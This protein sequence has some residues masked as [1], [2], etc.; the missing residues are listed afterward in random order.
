MPK[1]LTQDLVPGMITAEDIYTYT[2]QL[3]LPKDLVLTDKAI[4]KL[5]FYSVVSIRIKDETDEAEP[6]EELTYSEKIKSSPEFIKFAQD[7]EK[8]V[9]EV[10]SSLD[11]ILVQKNV[12][13]NVDKLLTEAQNL[14]K[15]SHNT[16][17]LFDMLHNMRYYDDP[18]YSHSLNV[19]VI[20]YAFGKW[21][22]FPDEDMN[23]LLLCG[24]LH[25]IG[26]LNIS[27]K[28]LAKPAKLTDAEFRIIRKHAQEGYNLLKDLSIDQHIKNAALMHHERCDGS[29]Y[30]NGLTG[31]QIDEYA[32][33]VAIA[34]IYDSMTSARIYR[35]PLCPFQVIEIFESE[36]LQKYDSKYILTFLEYIVNTYINNRIRLNNGQE[37]NI[38][39]INKRH[40]SRPLVHCG[41]QYIDLA[42]ERRLHIEAII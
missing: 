34:D 2:N 26:K 24:L 40:L 23:T 16:I 42:L 33:I 9:D 5:E 39:L 8:S 10:R 31:D 15:N 32:K 7:F 11:E 22:D 37:G 12:A 1:I 17:H 18:T 13:I 21:L 14:V 3:I 25:D 4:T 38:V 36:G 35:G 41:D 20:C 30:P 27:G 28:I 29:G 6:D 19:A